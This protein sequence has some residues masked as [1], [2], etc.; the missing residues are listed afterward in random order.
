LSGYEEAGFRLEFIRL[1][2]AGMTEKGVLR[3]F[4]RLS[5]F[6]TERNAGRKGYL[7]DGTL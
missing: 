2:R 1:R 6:E 4:A 3:L 7:S 5:Y